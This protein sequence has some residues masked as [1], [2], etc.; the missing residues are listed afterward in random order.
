VC[1]GLFG[2]NLGKNIFYS[3]FEK[4]QVTKFAFLC[5]IMNGNQLY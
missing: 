2:Y 1:L 3:D 4:E 5:F